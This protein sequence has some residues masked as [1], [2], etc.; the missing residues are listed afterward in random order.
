MAVKLTGPSIDHPC[1][2]NKEN[3]S[4]YISMSEYAVHCIDEEGLFLSGVSMYC[5]YPYEHDELHI[6]DGEHVQNILGRKGKSAI[7][8][9]RVVP[10]AAVALTIRLAN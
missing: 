10:F 1:Q 8:R 5:R 2:T 9:N 4:S 3:I 7:R 6:T